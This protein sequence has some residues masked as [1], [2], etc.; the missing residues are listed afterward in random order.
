MRRETKETKPTRA[1]GYVRVSTDEQGISLEAQRAKLEAYGQ[2][3]D[4]ELVAV[5][6]DEAVSAK[7]LDRPQLQQA[8]R[9][10]EADEAD[11]L[12]VVKL[13]RLTRSVRDL[14]SL[15]EKYFDRGRW[16]LLSVSE[17]IDTR[18]AGG[19]LVLHVLGSVAQ[20]ERET[21]GE[22]TSAALQHKQSKGEYIGGFA[23]F[24]F[25]TVE[26]KLESHR[27]E[28]L[29][30]TEACRLRGRGLSLRKI[31]GALEGE[32]HLSRDGSRFHPQQIAR[33]VV[34]A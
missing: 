6:T 26:G 14:G 12:L 18:T 19:R 24:G 20:W 25:R 11:A 15:L 16:S 2:V 17:N 1:I 3:Y 21:I 33:M 34:A 31:A 13:D 30:I 7:S 5:L 10:L 32:G 23:P 27:E 28:Q 22:R 9:M 8:L 4:L 29:A